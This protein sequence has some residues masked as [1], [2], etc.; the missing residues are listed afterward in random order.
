MKASTAVGFGIVGA[1]L[2]WYGLSAAKTPPK[3]P[4]PAPV[5]PP[6]APKAAAPTPA[7]PRPVAPAPAP[8]PVVFKGDPVVTY[9]QNALNAQKYGPLTV[10][11][12]WGPKTSAAVKSYQG[13]MGLDVTGT[14]TED[15][16]DS[17]ATS[18]GTPRPIGPPPPT[19][20]F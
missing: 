4:T 17:L 16:L 15:L 6:P 3:A 1:G 13:V 11:G 19:N 9:V 20:A 10:D 2:L 18:S 14:I 8:A 7:A 5:P 12:A